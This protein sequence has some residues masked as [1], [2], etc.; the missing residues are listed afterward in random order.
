MALDSSNVRVA[1][2]GRLYY[3]V[4]T[5]PA[6]T[7][8][9]TAL[10]ANWRDV[11]Y[12]SD[13]GV[14]EKRDLSTENITAWQNAENVRTVVKESSLTL[15]TTMIETNPNSLELFYGQAVDL[16]DGSL[17]IVPANTG[18]RR[19]FVLDYIDGGLPTRMYIPLGEVTEVDDM[20]LVSSAAV[21]YK[22]TITGYPAPVGYSAKKWYSALIATPAAA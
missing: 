2:D 11:G 14:T 3:D 7:D 9:A 15:E 6:P 19:S 13:D 10:P 8:G 12:I 18:G 5:A 21:G 20:E 17:P 16:S 22:V 1:V 4:T